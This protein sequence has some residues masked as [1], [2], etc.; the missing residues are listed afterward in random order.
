MAP[1]D[2]AKAVHLPLHLI[3]FMV[4]K[5][6]EIMKANTPRKGV[7]VKHEMKLI[8][9][10]VTNEKLWVLLYYLEIQPGEQPFGAYAAVYTPD[11][12]NRVVLEHGHEIGSTLF[13]S[14]R[15]I[16]YLFASVF[17]DNKLV[18]QVSRGGNAL[19]HV[20]KGYC[21]RRRDKSDSRTC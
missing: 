21:P 9:I 15:E 11:C 7:L 5:N 12:L 14:S 6:R 13:V 19:L 20:G 16:P 3:W 8:D 17:A 18:T 1:N 2:F 10:T 4:T